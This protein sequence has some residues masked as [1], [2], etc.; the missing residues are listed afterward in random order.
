MAGLGLT[1]TGRFAIL[2]HLVR[3]QR[4]PTRI[5]GRQLTLLSALIA[6]AA[7]AVPVTLVW[8]PPAGYVP[9][10]YVVGYGEV[11]GAYATEVDVGAVR[12]YTIPDLASGRTYFFS[13]R[14]YSGG[15]SSAWAREVAVAA[16]NE[17]PPPSVLYSPVVGLWANADEIGTGYALDFKHGVLVVTVYSYK[18]SGET[19]WYIASGPIVGATFTSRLD[20]FVGGQCIG[21]A[22]TGPPAAAGSDGTITILFSS[23]DLRDRFLARGTGHRDSTDS[24]LA[25]TIERNRS[26][27]APRKKPGTSR[28]FFFGWV[29]DDDLL[30]RWPPLR[31]SA[32]LT[33][34]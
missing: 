18:A 31:G 17:P 6:G 8:D 24:V 15:D 2:E 5:V 14:A 26:A 20:K 11:S 29:P 19:Q 34:T 13:V 10:G 32:A 33:M 28:A 21:C 16:L 4:G 3:L 1:G 25:C 9:A 7:N 27:R 12:T 23:C 30:R 22:Y